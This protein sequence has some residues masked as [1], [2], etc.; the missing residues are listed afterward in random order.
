[1][2]GKTIY[3][4]FGTGY[5]NSHEPKPL[6][7]EKGTILGVAITFEVWSSTRNV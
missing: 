1:M 5:D 7:N 2:D 4:L 3:T 6:V